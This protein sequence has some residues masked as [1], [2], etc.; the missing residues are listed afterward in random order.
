MKYLLLS[1][2]IL[3][4]PSAL[5]AQESPAEPPPEVPVA[6]Q[7]C[8]EGK[9][10]VGKEDMESIVVILKERKCLE[11]TTPSFKVSSVTILTD[12]AGR[13]YYQGGEKDPKNSK[14]I[15][16][17]EMDWCHYHVTTHGGV[18]VIAAVKEPPI[19]GFRFRPK[20]YLGYTVL[21]PFLEG[22]A[23]SKGID[24]GLMLDFVYY[25]WLNLN[26]ALGFRTFGIGLGAD[27]TTNFGGYLGYGVS[28]E[29][30]IN[31][32]KQPLHNIVIGFNFA[33]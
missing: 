17:L 3:L 12:T 23:F 13:I 16:S 31:S 14:A 6:E 27:L 25:R 2:V 26:A 15:Y 11:E 8:P 4:L 32:T 20:A 21:T 22:N 10:C 1:L 24:A 30:L 29:A 9:A 28:W 33:F 19:W 5:L 18:R 7:P